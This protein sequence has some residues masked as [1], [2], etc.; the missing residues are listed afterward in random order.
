MFNKYIIRAFLYLLNT[1]FT[2]TKNNNF[3]LN[4]WQNKNK[5]QNKVISN[6]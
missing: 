6:E 3:A 2:N 4:T 5:S 1:N